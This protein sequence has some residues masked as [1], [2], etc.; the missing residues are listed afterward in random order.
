[1]AGLQDTRLGAY[2]L[3]ECIGKG[4]MA[5]VYR[6][7]Q[8]SAFGREVAVKVIRGEFTGDEP[9]RRRFLREAH[10]V[11][12]LSH[13]NIL[14][15]IEFGDE[16]GLLYLVMPLVRE[17]TLRDLLS[18]HQ[19]PLSLEEALPLFGQLCDAVQYAHQEDIIHRDIKPQNVL[20]QRHTHILLADFG[21]ARDRFDTRMTTTGIGIGSV[22]YMAPEQA[23]GKADARSDIYSL[24][25]VLYQMLTGTM[26]YS[27]TAPIEVLVKKATDPAPDPRNFNPRLPAEMADILLMVLA[28]DPNQRFQSAGA[29]G[30]AIQQVRLPGACPSPLGQMIWQA[31]TE[32]PVPPE[33]DFATTLR[34]QQRQQQLEEQQPRRSQSFGTLPTVPAAEPAEPTLHATSQTPWSQRNDPRPHN[35]GNVPAPRRSKYVLVAAALVVAL[36][37]A[38]GVS[39]MASGHFGL[40]WLRPG[41]ADTGAQLL[42]PTPTPVVTTLPTPGTGGT[43]PPWPSKP[44]PGST[45]TPAPTAQPTSQPTPTP[46]PTV[47]PTPAPTDTPTP[48]PTDAPTPQPTDSSSS[49]PTPA[50]TAPPD[51]IPS[52]GASPVT[53]P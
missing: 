21:I 14:P 10:A 42:T 26:P 40:D 20:L 25:I 8:L 29:L 22:E 24:G 39:S 17:G 18:H 19:G 41:T 51:N 11:S 53:T 9:F 43:T 38:L 31:S 27:G 33:N 47:T 7:K 4:G 32:A 34:H 52:G 28:K 44:Q 1:M 2:E 48:V 5:D 6:A 37:L 46:Q 35:A 49:H 45:P 50:P 3:L 15:L 12:R 16:K 30:E 23:E 36:L 13:P